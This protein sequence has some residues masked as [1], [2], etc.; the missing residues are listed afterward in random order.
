MTTEEKNRTARQFRA[1]LP[2]FSR[3]RSSRS[4]FPRAFARRAPFF[5]VPFRS[6][7]ASFSRPFCSCADL[8]C[9]QAALQATCETMITIIKPKQK[10]QDFIHSY[11]LI[12]SMLWLFLF[13]LC[14]Y[15]LCISPSFPSRSQRVCFAKTCAPLVTTD[16]FSERRKF[17]DLMKCYLLLFLAFS[18]GTCFV[19]VNIYIFHFLC[20]HL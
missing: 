4:F 7:R 14:L 1:L 5:P 6:P 2:F 10:L 13:M 9:R 11:G 15:N 20:S 19:F 3:F 18:A 12:T 17:N 16:M 8:C